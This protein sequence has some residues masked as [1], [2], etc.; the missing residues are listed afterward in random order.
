[1][2]SVL[3]LMNIQTHWVFCEVTISDQRSYTLLVGFWYDVRYEMDIFF[4]IFRWLTFVPMSSA[5]LLNGLL[6]QADCTSPERKSTAEEL[7]ALLNTT[8]ISF[9]IKLISNWLVFPCYGVFNLLIRSLHLSRI[10][11]N[12]SNTLFF[13]DILGLSH[14]HQRKCIFLWG[15]GGILPLNKM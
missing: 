3:L 7:L 13:H 1:M 11:D 2:S 14:S 9:Y 8:F 10:N 15:K 4:A 5:N 6:C 12:D